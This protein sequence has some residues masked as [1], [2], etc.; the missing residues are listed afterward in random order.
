MKQVTKAIIDSAEKTKAFL[1]ELSN[2]ELNTLEVWSTTSFPYKF[3]EYYSITLADQ[4]KFHKAVKE[5]REKRNLP[6]L[7]NLTEIDFYYKLSK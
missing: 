5:E 3:S 4:A 1:E 2:L 7:N 6:L